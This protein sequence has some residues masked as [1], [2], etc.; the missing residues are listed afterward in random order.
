MT[1]KVTAHGTSRPDW[2]IAAELADCSSATT[3]GSTSVDAVTDAI[4][5]TVPGFGGVTGAALDAH[6]GGGWSPPLRRRRCRPG[7]RSSPRRNSYDYRLVVSRKLYDQAVGTA[8]S[9]SLA[10]LAPGAR[11]PTST[12]TTSTASAS[13]SATEVR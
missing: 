13:R 11:L 2:M 12:R 7:I 8:D 10:P 6:A 1:Q 5:A 9:P 3:S 4:A